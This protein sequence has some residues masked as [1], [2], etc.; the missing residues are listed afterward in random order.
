MD[1]LARNELTASFNAAAT[2]L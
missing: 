2:Q 1:V